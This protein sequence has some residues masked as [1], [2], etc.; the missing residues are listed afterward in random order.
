MTFPIFTQIAQTEG[1]DAAKSR[2]AMCRVQPNLFE[3][4][5]YLLRIAP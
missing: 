5:D 4:W 1:L 3:L 2:A